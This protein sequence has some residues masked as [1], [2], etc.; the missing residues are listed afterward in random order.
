M[1][2]DTIIL[3]SDIAYLD[4]LNCDSTIGFSIKKSVRE[5]YKDPKVKVTT[6]TG[7]IN[8]SDCHRNIT[9]YFSEDEGSLEKIDKAIEIL[10]QFRK[11]YAKAEKNA[12]RANKKT[13]PA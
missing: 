13:V 7:H 1:A 11:E 8:L 12:A 3:A 4:V 2:D 5:G 10:M 6:L 9:W